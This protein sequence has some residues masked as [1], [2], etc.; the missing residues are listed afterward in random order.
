MNDW[1]DIDS[2]FGVPEEV[3]ARVSCAGAAGK[4]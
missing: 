4:M 1:Q 3:L 2:C